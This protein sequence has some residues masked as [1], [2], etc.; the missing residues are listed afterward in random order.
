MFCQYHFENSLTESI[1]NNKRNTFPFSTVIQSDD[2]VIV[3]IFELCGFFLSLHVNT[4]LVGEIKLRKPL[5]LF[6]KTKHYLGNS[7][8]ASKWSM[9]FH[10]CNNTRYEKYGFV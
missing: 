4:A 6:A 2:Y 7:E 10:S 9:Q 3:N 1:K 8:S 5:E